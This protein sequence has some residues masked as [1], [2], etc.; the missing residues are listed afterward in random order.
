MKRGTVYTQEKTRWYEP[1]YDLIGG[2][3]YTHT[4]GSLY[5]LSNKAAS[6]I[7]NMPEGSLRFF[8]NEGKLNN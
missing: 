5:V 4:W 3:Y 6:I 7:S 8:N 2:S 1:Q